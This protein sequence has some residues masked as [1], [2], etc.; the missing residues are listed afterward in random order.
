LGA[1]LT[2]RRRELCAERPK[3]AEWR[4]P[5]VYFHQNTLL[6]AKKPI[7]INSLQRHI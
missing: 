6:A 3:T 1:K 5:T 7:Q 4:L 2:S